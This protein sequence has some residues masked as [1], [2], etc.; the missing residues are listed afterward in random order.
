MSIFRSNL[1]W[2]A[3]IFGEEPFCCQSFFRFHNSYSFVCKA[4]L[5]WYSVPPGP[6]CLFVSFSLFSL[7]SSLSQPFSSPSFLLFKFKTSFLLSS[8]SKLFCDPYL[9]QNRFRRSI[10]FKAKSRFSPI[11]AFVGLRC[12][13]AA[14]CCKMQHIA[15]STAPSAYL[16][17]QGKCPLFQNEKKKLDWKDFC[18]QIWILLSNVYFCRFGQRFAGCAS[19]LRLFGWL[20]QRYGLD[21]LCFRFECPYSECA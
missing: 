21:Q 19:R 2:E 18:E 7:P 16:L 10:F 11:V 5:F 1:R 3:L 20:Y 13:F 4:F 15:K 12:K 8:I 6:F 9:S 17:S 14:G